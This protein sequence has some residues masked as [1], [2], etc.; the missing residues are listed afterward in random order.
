MTAMTLHPAL[1]RLL[2][3]RGLN[4]QAA[5][6]FLS[7]NLKD[8]PDLTQMIDVEKAALRLIKAM[9][10]NEKIAVYGERGAN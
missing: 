5:Q 10:Q 1:Q 4:A 7:W 9:E 2:E 3:K 8:I 6:D